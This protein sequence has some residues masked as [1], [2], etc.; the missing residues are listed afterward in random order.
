MPQ[1]ARHAAPPSSVTPIAL[2]AKAPT[3]TRPAAAAAAAVVAPAAMAAIARPRT[4]AAPAKTSPYVGAALAPAE[5]QTLM[6]HAGSGCPMGP[7]KGCPH[8]EIPT[9]ACKA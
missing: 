7:C 1:A 9:G 8:F 2:R 4:T 6:R 3:F 5:I